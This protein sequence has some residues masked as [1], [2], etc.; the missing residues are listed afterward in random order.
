MQE[1]RGWRRLNPVVPAS[2]AILSIAVS[3]GFYW[4][5]FNRMQR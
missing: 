1:I 3:G 4:E 2:G 5:L